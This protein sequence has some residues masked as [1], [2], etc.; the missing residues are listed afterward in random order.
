MNALIKN[1]FEISILFRGVFEAYKI[2]AEEFTTNN[3]GLFVKKWLVFFSNEIG[4]ENKIF[5]ND[6]ILLN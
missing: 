4:G 6:D 5:V 1:V 2:F 3:A